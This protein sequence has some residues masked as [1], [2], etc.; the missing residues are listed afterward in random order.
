MDSIKTFI[1]VGFVVICLILLWYLFDSGSSQNRP[2]RQRANTTVVPENNPVRVNPAPET[3]RNDASIEDTPFRDSDVVDNSQRTTVTERQTSRPQLTSRSGAVSYGKKRFSRDNKWGQYEGPMKN[4]VPH[5]F[6]IFRYEN[7]D[8]YVGQYHNGQRHS[9]GNSYF[10]KTKKVL[11]RQ[12]NHG[13]MLE[14]KNVSTCSF[15]TKN[16]T[17]A[18][19][20]GTYYGPICQGRPQG[21][22]VYVYP[23][24]NKFMGTYQD[25][26]RH[27]KGNM[28]Y[29]DG[30]VETQ[31]YSRGD[32]L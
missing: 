9:Y 18:G 28:I 7:G 8:V 15:G 29:T 32:M 27:G 20:T 14:S 4:G 24:G 6:G 2:A 22:G 10:K 3:R 1:N 13:E 30:T 23:N 26:V 19:K 11:L 17:N 16:F 5:G 12:F 25:G 31:S 21:Y